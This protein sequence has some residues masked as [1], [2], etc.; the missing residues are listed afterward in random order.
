MVMLKEVTL[1]ACT[2]PVVAI[3]SSNF[4]QAY[5]VSTLRF[6]RQVLAAVMSVVWG[7]SRELLLQ[8][9]SRLCWGLQML[10]VRQVLFTL[11]LAVAPGL[12]QR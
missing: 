7:N 12:A 11:C 6:H 2:P 4:P 1:L 5:P 9:A 8:M 3:P 10:T